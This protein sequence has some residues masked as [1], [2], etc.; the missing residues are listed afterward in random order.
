MAW[1]DA[2]RAAA[3]EA[4]RRNRQLYPKPPL[5]AGKVVRADKYLMA[6]IDRAG[7]A[8][9]IK[10]ARAVVRGKM[11]PPTDIFRYQRRSWM[12]AYQG[13]LNF[14]RITKKKK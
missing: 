13:T 4:R 3:L 6:R 9:A 14:Y 11:S 1:S 12:N 2:A 5:S 7:I 8:D 10:T